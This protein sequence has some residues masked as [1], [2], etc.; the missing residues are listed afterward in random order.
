VKD[1]DGNLY[2]RSTTFLSTLLTQMCD[3]KQ[4]CVSVVTTL[5]QCGV[6]DVF[7]SIKSLPDCILRHAALLETFAKNPRTTHLIRRR[8]GLSNP[9]PGANDLSIPFPIIVSIDE[10]AESATAP[11]PLKS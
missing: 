7:D 10:V 6:F 1:N 9:S 2:F 5:M 8:D 11:H 3:C 4:S